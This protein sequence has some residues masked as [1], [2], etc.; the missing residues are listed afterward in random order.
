LDDGPG[1]EV[2]SGIYLGLVASAIIAAFGMT[3]VV[4]RVQKP[5][6]VVSADDDVD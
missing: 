5:Y 2:G 4:R 3:I 1:A 6:T